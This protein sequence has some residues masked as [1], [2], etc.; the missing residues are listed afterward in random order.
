MGERLELGN[1]IASVSDGTHRHVAWG[2]NRDIVR[3]RLWR[4]GGNDPDVFYASD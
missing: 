4:N 3:N 1:Y 2:D